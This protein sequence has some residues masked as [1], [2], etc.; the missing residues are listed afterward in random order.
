MA[1]LL[2]TSITGTLSTTGNTGVGTTS[3]DTKLHVWNGDSGGA[4]YEASGITIENSG[5]AS[6]NFLSGAGNDAYVFFG[7]SSAGNAGYVGYENT[8]NRLVLRSSDYVS[9]L[10]STGEVIR[11]DGGNVGIGTTSPTQKLSIRGSQVF[12]NQ[13]ADGVANALIAEISSQARGYSNQGA[14]MASIQFRTNPSTWY[15]GDIAFLTNSTDGTDPTR[16]A[17]ERMRITASGNVGIGNTSPTAKLQVGAEVHP[18]ATGIEVAAGDGGAN[19]LAIDESRNHNWFPYTNGSNYYSAVEHIFRNESHSVDWMRITSAG[20]V[21]IGT[22]SPNAKLDVYGTSRF[23]HGGTS[24]YTEFNNSNEINTYASNGTISAMYLNWVSGGAVNIARSAIYAQS[25][26]NVGIGTTSPSEHLSI[27]GAGDQALSIYSSTTGVQG[28]ARTFIKLFGQNTASTKHEQVRIASAPGA[29]AS[30]AGQLIISTNNTSGDLTERLRIDEIGDVGI[31]TTNPRARLNVWTPS[32]TGLQTALRLNNPSGF[33]NL[34]TGAKIVFSQDRSTSEDFPMG[35]LGVG[36]ANAGSSDFGYMFFSTKNTGAIGERMRITANG[37]V[38]IGTTSP[39][40]KLHIV[41]GSEYIDGGLGANNSSPYTSANRLIF[42]NDYNDVARG[43]N[44]ITLYDASWL[45]GFGIHNNTLAYYSGGI[46]N[47]YQATNATNAVS[48]MTLTS[49]GSLGIGTTNPAEKLEVVGN[50][51]STVSGGDAI[52]WAKNGT[53]QSYLV[54][55]TTGG[56]F[57]LVGT[58]TNH[59]FILRTN[60]T[61]KV[62]I[63][64]AGYVG[65][66]NTAPNVK[67]HVGSSGALGGWMSAHF[68]DGIGIAPSGSRAAFYAY[69]DGSSFFGINAYNYETNVYLP[70]TVGWGGGNVYIATD[71]GNVG[72]GTTSPANKLYIVSSAQNSGLS[73]MDFNGAGGW[74]GGINLGISGLSFESLGKVYTY[75]TNGGPGTVAGDMRFQTASGSALSDRMV[76]TSAGNV[77]IGTTSPGEKLDVSGNIKTSGVIYAPTVLVNNHSDNTKGYRIHTTSGVSVSAMFTN[78]ANA[79]VIGAGAFDQVQ[80]NK[81]VLVSGQVISRVPS[82]IEGFYN[83]YFSGDA[84][85]DGTEPPGMIAKYEID[86]GGTYSYAGDSIKL[87]GPNYLFT[88]FEYLGPDSLLF[89]P[90]GNGGGANGPGLYAPAFYP[91]SDRKLKENITPVSGLEIVK[92]LQG[93]EFDWKSSGKHSSG[94]IAQEVE[95]VVPHAVSD[96]D[97]HKALNYNALLAYQNEAIKELSD[98]VDLLKQEIEILKNK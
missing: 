43:P 52:L 31:G 18:S 39:S 61:E 10:D 90:W 56:S 78:S 35:E 97:T 11:I 4:P 14:N 30:T 37:N 63:T 85:G 49:G 89:D 16:P 75:L 82:S 28:T 86:S 5:R 23:W 24:H 62:R 88:V 27:E 26:G 81:K 94:F 83:S 65:I 92:K 69:S 47:W 74:G 6:L 2:S 84:F 38:G 64:T 95:E 98:M 54:A 46:H 20:N 25:A 19:L 48:L 57:G 58:S 44:K 59:D 72:I 32:T 40:Y 8:A 53:V 87:N 91:T 71:G 22:E 36:Q 70:L 68:Q 77:G 9:L 42:N 55:N 13:N 3:P 80:L 21:G 67:L 33:D 45:G 60:N 76:I 34:N 17:D 41:G 29:T 66:G 96:T 15:F 1:N 93:V 51:Q 50:I 12:T 79:L 73:V 7:N